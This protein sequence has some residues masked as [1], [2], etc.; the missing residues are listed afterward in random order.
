MAVKFL[1]A[2]K[3]PAFLAALAKNARVVAPVKTNGVV[4][5]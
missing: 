4:Q 5:F 3:L 2:D 1:K